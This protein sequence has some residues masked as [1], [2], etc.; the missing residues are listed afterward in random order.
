M[1][2][3]KSAD[4]PISVAAFSMQDIEA[5]ARKVIFRAQRKAEQ[6]LAAAHIE[7]QAIKSQARTDGLAEGRRLGLLQGTEEGKAS[8]HAQALTEHGA[9]MTKLIGA[10]TEAVR[11]L[12]DS[13]DH[14]HSHVLTEVVDLACRIARRVTKR[15]GAVDPQVLCRN[16]TEALA[17]AVHAADVRIAVNPSQLKTLES[18]MPN[19]RLAWPQL[20][21]V[22]LLAD[23]AIAPGGVRVFTAHGQIDGD[24]DAQLD[25]IFAEL[26]PDRAP[27]AT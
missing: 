4:A 18:E 21:H 13:R 22:D 16:V 2:L 7:A 5:A 24:L 25:R 26:L 17:L 10:L 12:D 3:I 6:V 1:G 8:G 20:K 14:L 9:A 19:L 27:E 23:P 11:E 15:Q